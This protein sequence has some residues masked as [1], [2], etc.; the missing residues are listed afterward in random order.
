[1]AK[2]D[3][4][5]LCNKD[6]G[7]YDGSVWYSGNMNTL[8]CKSCYLKWCRNKEHKLLKNKY[9]KAKPCTKLWYKMCNEQQKAFD[10]WY[11]ANGGTDD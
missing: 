11:Y 3:R 9:K 5:N 2:K 8:L 1:M 10:K 7:N 4:C 6:R